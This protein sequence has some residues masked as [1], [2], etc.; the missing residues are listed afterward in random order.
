MQPSVRIARPARCHRETFFPRRKKTHLQKMIRGSNV[1]DPRQAHF[2]YQAVLQRFEQSLDPS[3]GLR[4][5][6]CDP[7]DP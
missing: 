4:T 3:F 1:V 2:L 5:V 6:C 7:F